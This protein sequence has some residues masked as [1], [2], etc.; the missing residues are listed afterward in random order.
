MQ[1][2]QLNFSIFLNNFDQL[3]TA[4]HSSINL[5]TKGS[6]TK[7][8]LADFETFAQIWVGGSGKNL[9]QKID[10]IETKYLWEGGMQKSSQFP[11]E[12]FIFIL[13]FSAF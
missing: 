10:A 3:L 11:I 9:I 2:C 7:K 4:N 1:I 8:K 5:D 12:K 6:R 13:L